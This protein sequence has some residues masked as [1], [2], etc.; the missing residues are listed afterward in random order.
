MPAGGLSTEPPQAPLI[1]YTKSMKKTTL[2]MSAFMA[3]Y[4]A[5]VIAEAKQR[6]AIRQQILAGTYVPVPT[7]TWNISDRD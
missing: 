5:K 2:D 3:D 6:E 4:T 7:T 1:P